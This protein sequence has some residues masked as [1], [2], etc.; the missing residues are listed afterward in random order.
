MLQP[1]QLIKDHRTDFE[2]G[3]VKDVLDGNLDGFIEAYL[4]L[5][6]GGGNR[7]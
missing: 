2:A 6:A 7:S 4:D 1:Y 5:E 3:N